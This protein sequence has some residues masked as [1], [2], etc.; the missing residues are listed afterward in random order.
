MDHIALVLKPPLHVKPVHS[1]KQF[2]LFL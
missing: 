2:L 1:F